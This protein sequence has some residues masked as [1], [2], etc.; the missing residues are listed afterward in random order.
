MDIKEAAHTSAA[1]QP[2]AEH[3]PTERRRI[4]AAGAAGVAG[5]AMS[6]LPWF[7]GAALARPT[8]D[9]PPDSEADADAP[10]GTQ[11][12][13]TDATQPPTADT[14]QATEFSP[15]TDAA[16]TTTAPPKRPSADDVE[17]LNSAQ[18][19][20]LTIR[21]LYDVAL[22]SG[23]FEEP[24]LTQI[25]AIREAHE[26]Y[27]TAVSGVLS[28]EGGSKGSTTFFDESEAAFGG[29]DMAEFALNAAAIEDSAAATHIEII[30]QLLGTEGASL[31]ASIA[32]IEA[33][34]ATLLKALAGKALEAQLASSGE[35]LPPS[36]YTVG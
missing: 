1:A 12:E 14:T 10:I 31:L 16:T 25:R 5:A 9:S 23:A 19:L 15:A 35:A 11:P 33:R 13:G 30:G 17:L 7:K 22:N 36:D 6:L 3:A 18:A 20:E 8:S 21:D 32:V 26:G 27:G 29:S 34:H 24:M 2:P 28:S 4:L